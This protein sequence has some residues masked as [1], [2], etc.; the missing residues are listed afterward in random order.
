[1][2]AVFSKWGNSLAVRIPNAFAQDLGVTAG[3]AAEVTVEQGRLVVI[4]VAMPVYDLDQLVAGIT[5]ENRHGEIQG[6]VAVGN[7]I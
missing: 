7:E 1:M 6:T 2:K 4:P 5:D 3:R